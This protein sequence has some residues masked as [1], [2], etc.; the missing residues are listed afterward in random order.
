MT[1]KPGALCQIDA[2]T[3]PDSDEIRRYNYKNARLWKM[4]DCLD[5]DVVDYDIVL[6]VIAVKDKWVLLTDGNAL[7]W[8]MMTTVSEL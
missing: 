4:S 5:Y 8:R 2:F 7:G 6:L 1:I 3:A